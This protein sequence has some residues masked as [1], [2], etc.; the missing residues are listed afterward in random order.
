MKKYTLIMAI[1]GISISMNAQNT[2]IKFGVKSGV[3][4]SKYTPDIPDIFDNNAKM[5]DYQGKIGFYIGGFINVAISEKFK[6]QPELLFSNQGTKSDYGDITIVDSNGV[7]LREEKVESKTNE[8][9]I[10]LPI[11][12][13]Y[14]FYD[15]LNLE[16]GFQ[17]GYILNIEEKFNNLEGINSTEYDTFDFGVNIGIGFEVIQN[18]RIN[19]RYFLGLLEREDLIRP[20]VFSLGI[21]YQL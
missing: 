13:Q 11:T 19:T 14:F 20:S 17:L 5:I 4:S 2:A 16:G 15:K 18:F 1:L 21:E 7:F 6:I 12:L 10:S 3:N 9:R 8:S